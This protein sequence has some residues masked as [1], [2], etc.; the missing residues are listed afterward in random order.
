MK[1]IYDSRVGA[2]DEYVR[3]F[4]WAPLQAG[5]IFAI[6]PENMGLDL[7]DH[8]D[9]MRAML[10]K[11]VRSYALDAL[12]A[13]RAASATI[14]AATKF[15]HRI[16]G[17]EHLTQ[18]AVGED[19]RLIGDGISGAS[20]WAEGRYV[21]VCGFSTL[22]AGRHSEFSTRMSRPARRRMQ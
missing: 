2:I 20:L 12:E 14:A 21:H 5:L 22:G 13:P 18:P 16:G 6:G 15:I 19:V 8:P 4:E 1:A 10:P 9:A 11:L 7:L 17:A 3:A